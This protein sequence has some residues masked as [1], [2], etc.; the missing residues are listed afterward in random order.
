MFGMC[1]RSKS[2]AHNHYATDVLRAHPAE[3]RYEPLNGYFLIRHALSKNPFALSLSKCE[4]ILVLRHA[5]RVLS[6]RMPHTATACPLRVQHERQLC[7]LNSGSFAELA[8]LV[9][10]R[11][12]AEWDRQAVP[13][14]DRHDG[15]SEVDEFLFVE[16]SQGLFAQAF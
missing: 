7:S 3:L 16:G 10:S 8:R 15:K 6:G 1:R 5:V 11:G 9:A 13:A 14:V 12:C 4:R 2:I